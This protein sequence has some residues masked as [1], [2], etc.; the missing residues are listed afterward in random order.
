MSKTILVVV[1]S[2]GKIAK[3]QDILGD[4][5]TV[6]ATKGHI[7][8][9]HPKKMSVDI[10]NDFTPSY[11][12]LVGKETTIDMLKKKYKYSSDVLIATD[13]DREGEMI[14]W[15]VADILNL[16]NPKRIVFTSITKNDILSAVASPHPINY[17]MVD[18]QKCR[19]ILDRLLGFSIS[20]ILWNSGFSSE[21]SK[22]ISAGRVQSVVVKI[23]ID[24]EN[25]IKNF[26]NSESA[27]HFKIN[28]DFKKNDETILHGSLID[29]DKNNEFDYKFSQKFMNDLKTS[30]FKINNIQSG[31]KTKS[32]PHPFT[33][34]TLQQEAG[35]KHGFTVKKTMDCAQRLY[36]A[37]LITYMRTDSRILS[38]EC[39]ND[40]EKYITDVFGEKYL[41]I[42]QHKTKSKNTQEA[43]EAIRPT[44]ITT[45]E[46]KTSNNDDNKLY[47]LI[48]STTIASQMKPAIYNTLKIII[49]ISHNKSYNFISNI[50]KLEFDGYLKILKNNSNN[51]NNE[52]ESTFTEGDDLEITS[53]SAIQTYNK[54][55]PRYNEVSLVNILDPKNLNIGRP[56]TYASIINKIKEIGY[57]QLKD[58]EGV[59]KNSVNILLTNN[60]NKISISET[61]NKI[62]LGKETN[63]MVPTDIAINVTNFL[64]N[65]F[66]TIMDYK[67]TSNMEIKLDE[68]SNDNISWISILNDFYNI[69]KPPIDK[70]NNARTETR[71]IGNH[72]V[73]NTE[74]SVKYGRFGPYV[75]VADGNNIYRAPIKL[76]L[77]IENI[78]MDDVL[79][80]FK[81]PKQL[82]EHNDKQILLQ[83]GK[84][85]IYL[86]YD[87]QSISVGGLS[88][89]DI[90]LDKAIELIENC[91]KR[92][93]KEIKDKNTI[94]T[95][96][97]GPYGNYINMKTS[98]ISRNIK[99]P[100]DKSIE[101][102][103]LDEIKE[104][105]NKPKPKP[106]KFYKKK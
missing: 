82:G 80:L 17:K 106:K 54:P 12:P 61:T 34:S 88:E 28:A 50:D 15:H 90:N 5:Y 72:P 84:F 94:Y 49:K 22:V 44:H 24:R 89:G 101:L 47:H 55:L 91:N 56:S 79:E 14:A 97:N 64:N 41:D 11:F 16:K 62:Y 19:R 102:I 18:S 95:I 70:I 43:H 58:I 81:Y 35:R 26:F 6:V 48:W 3:I 9:L 59:E 57:I 27:Y 67:F 4:K 63:K 31:Q 36:E 40:I 103:T 60:N 46:I 92:K 86:V 25:E 38:K 52:T 20:P 45:D 78:K 33:T 85:G 29:V 99:L 2:P 105:V 13:K 93:L 21:K 42:H 65:N 73:Y 69:I 51:D 30:K 77:T 7:L 23:I 71:I 68:I 37:G 76:P 96:L 98:K 1:E 10:N 87:K 100:N 83:K 53:G 75:T 39:L 66:P 104:L 8:D 32:P 74:V